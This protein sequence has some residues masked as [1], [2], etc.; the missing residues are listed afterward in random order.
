[1]D[2][3]ILDD[4]E[5]ANTVF[6]Q[7]TAAC[8]TQA[9]AISSSSSSVNAASETIPE[10]D[11]PLNTQ[12]S[13]A[14]EA[15]MKRL[16]VLSDHEQ[17]RM[18]ELPTER[19][20]QIEQAA[21]ARGFLLPGAYSLRR[22]LIR[23]TTGGGSRYFGK[24]N[25]GCPTAANDHAENFERQLEVWL[26]KVAPGAPYRTEQQLKQAGSRFTPDF[27]F[28]GGV[29]ING[30]LVH[31]L[32]CKT[33]YG[34]SLLAQTK[35]VPVGKLKDQAARYFESFGPGAFVFLNGFSSDLLTRGGMDAG[36]VLLLDATPLDVSELFQPEQVHKEE[37]Y[38]PLDLVGRV[39]G[40]GGATLARLQESTG[41]GVVL[42]HLPHTCIVVLT[43]NTSAA[44]ACAARDAVTALIAPQRRP[45]S[46]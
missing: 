34:S 10:F 24:H 16:L 12:P 7:V 14:D 32:D 44:D 36:Q 19:Q 28:P 37:V 4:N 17:G 41:C 26:R 35:S 22:Q 29:R 20:H 11:W 25:M 43:S 33:Y 27:L 9:K 46:Y 40:R 23:K 42:H 21:V 15:F 13:M 38:C 8:S 31:W 1:M 18:M 30:S 39:I 5:E 6:R 2:D 45:G 3:L